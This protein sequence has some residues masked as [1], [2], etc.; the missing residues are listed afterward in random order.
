MLFNLSLTNGEFPE[1]YKKSD[2][3]PLH[4]SKSKLVRMNYRPISL[5]PG[6]VKDIRKNCL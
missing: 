1:L 4:K 2:V 3:V 5:L 6:N